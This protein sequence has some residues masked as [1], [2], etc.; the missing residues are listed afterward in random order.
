MSSIR[1][2][3]SR[4]LSLAVALVAL[5]LLPGIQ[6]G[7]AT[8]GEAGFSKLTTVLADLA[9]SVPQESGPFSKSQPAAAASF[10]PEATPKSVRDAMHGRL[11][12]INSNNEVQVYILMSAVT[13]ANLRQLEA[14]GA[15]IEITDAA[16]KRVQ[17]RIPAT[18]LQSVADVPSVNFIRLPSY[19]VRMTGSVD[20]EGDAILQAI[21]A[22]QQLHVD[23]T[24]VHVGVISDGLKGIFASGSACTANSDGTSTC[25][26]IAGGPISTGDLPSPPANPTTGTRNSSGTL[27]SS[28]GGITGTPFPSGADLEGLPPAGCG[29]A[30]AGAE[31]TALLEIVYDIAPGAQLAFANFQTSMDFENAVNSLASSNDVVVDDISF[32]GE[33][34]DGTSSISTNTAAALNSATNPIRGYYTA[35]GNFATGHYYGLYDDS[36]VN[37]NTISGISNSGDLHLFQQT[38]DTSVQPPL[39][40][41]DVLGLG[42]KPYNVIE[43]PAGA[44]AVIFLTWDDTWGASSNNYDL[45]L[46]EQSTGKVV[47]SSTDVQNGTQDPVEEIDYTNNTGAQDF[48]RIVVQNVNQAQAKHLNIFTFAPECASA[49]PSP[50]APPGHERL[51]FN[52]ATR[53]LA[54][55]SDAGGSPAS[56]VTVAAICSASQKAMEAR[57]T[58]ASCADTTN[59]TIEYF[60]SQ[61]PTLDGRLKPEISGIDGVSITGAGNFENPFFGTSAA[62]PHVAGI[63]A[64]L[65]QSASCLLSTSSYPADPG[66]ARTNLS[67]LI[68][69]NATLVGGAGPAS[70]DDVFGYGRIDALASALQTVPVTGSVPN[71]ILSGNTPQGASA[72]TLPTTGF[73]DP[74][75]CPLTV[76]ATSGCSTSGSTVNCPFGTYA[77]K[78]V[79]S[80][81]G[82]TFSPSAQVQVTVTNF[83]VT[84]SPASYPVTAGG[85]ATYTVTVTPT[86]YP[87]PFNNPIALACSS[88]S[89]PPG[90]VCSFDPTTVTPGSGSANSTLT[91]TTTGQ[92]Q[93]LAPPAN[94][95]PPGR[96][97]RWAPFSKPQRGVPPLALWLGV[98]GFITLGWLGMR[99]AGRRRL[100]ALG[101]VAGALAILAIHAACGGRGSS[102]ASAPS[103]S[104]SPPSGL[105]FSSPIGTA[106]LPQTV[107]LTTT[108]GNTACPACTVGSVLIINSITLSNNVFA[109]EANNCN[110]TLGSPASCTIDITFTPTQSGIVNATL[111]ISDNASGSPQT[112]SLSGTGQILTPA[113]SYPITVTGTVNNS[114]VQSATATLVVQSQ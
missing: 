104:L 23:G 18:R 34:D 105:S 102:S 74:D 89:V 97:R 79:A 55:E 73:T 17:A 40:T 95:A 7:D 103:V 48:F 108:G 10:S 68:L 47:A 12:R 92:T 99:L 72:V 114:L 59:S 65:L 70:P 75:S 14:S 77:A 44:E 5:F 26:G 46:V 49:G 53:S 43:L 42:P 80:N 35:A 22:R 82:V 84:V 54:A 57:P 56:I 36:K 71:L 25:Q 11:L 112:L 96:L 101:A 69:D 58:D 93:S 28:S 111:S 45:Y 81:N 63:A 6:R 16:H 19:G 9:R 76:T 2:G 15:T 3:G 60:S 90:A 100:A 83:G 88:S 20:T 87:N 113:G 38:D 13:D 37:G 66:T 8:S 33:P 91:I 62:A 78:L 4:G 31:G 98:T 32:L 61:G 52:T 50:L 106:T 64:L 94:G 41:T 27:I 107:T 85:T 30:G 29:F 110:S 86:P 21:Q 67:N 1:K 51:N 109:I 39:V 24:G